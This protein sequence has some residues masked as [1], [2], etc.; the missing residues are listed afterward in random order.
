MKSMQV[1]K[2][3]QRLM[4]LKMKQKN[5]S[6]FKFGIVEAL[7]TLSLLGWGYKSPYRD[8]I[9]NY[10]VDGLLIDTCIAHDTGYWET[11]I[12]DKRYSEFMIIVS[13]WGDRASAK[14]GHD[15]WV[16]ALTGNKL[17]KEIEDV[18]IDKT[19]KLLEATNG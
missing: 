8:D 3:I 9:F 1:M 5:I 7:D 16:A 19:Y 11:G 12:V 10:K 18:H 13:E 4:R 15:Y 2:L 6:G 17:P 14:K